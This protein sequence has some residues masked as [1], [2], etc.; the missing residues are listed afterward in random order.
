MNKESLLKAKELLLNI[1]TL[2][3]PI[4]DKYEL[5][6]NL[7]TLLNPEN[8]SRHIKVLQ[9]EFNEELKWKNK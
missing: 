8:Y 7:D 4:E 2:D 6:S 1:D 3:I 9:R 5:L